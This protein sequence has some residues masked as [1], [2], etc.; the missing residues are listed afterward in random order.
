MAASI[1]RKAIIC[2]EITKIPFSSAKIYSRRV[3][4]RGPGLSK[5]M[6][7]FN[8]GA[9]FQSDK[10]PFEPLR[11]VRYPLSVRSDHE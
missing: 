10:A 9:L 2:M 1:Q 8:F 7:S 4:T 5:T 11:H 3:A 6:P